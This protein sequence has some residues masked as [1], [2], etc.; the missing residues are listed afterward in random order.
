MTARESLGQSILKEWYD[1][2]AKYPTNFN[3]P[4]DQFVNL[5]QSSTNG[6][7]LDNFGMAVGFAEDNIG[8]DAIRK[9][10]RDLAISTQGQIPEFPDGSPKSSFW[11]DALSNVAQARLSNLPYL[12]KLVPK[13]AAESAKGLGEFALAGLSIYLIGTLVVGGF[14]LYFALKPAGKAHAS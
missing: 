14:A 4:F 13:V 11:F 7:F 12:Q 5:L 1:A 3:Y 10:M 9:S 6:T 2:A 8:I